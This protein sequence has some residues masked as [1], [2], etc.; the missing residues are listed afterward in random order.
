MN[1]L[2][3]DRN[4]TQIGQVGTL[5]AGVTLDQFIAQYPNSLVNVQTNA[6]RS[7]LSAT[8]RF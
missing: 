3:N 8:L 7:F 2:L 6:P 1:N 5:P 4:A